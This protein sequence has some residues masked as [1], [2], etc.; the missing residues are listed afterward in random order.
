MALLAACLTLTVSWM[1][2]AV[3]PVERMERAGALS[4]QVQ[5]RGPDAVRV[6]LNGASLS[7]ATGLQAV[8]T[9]AEGVAKGGTQGSNP[10]AVHPSPATKS[11]TDATV[12]PA[13][14]GNSSSSSSNGIGSSSD[15][16][17]KGSEQGKAAHTKPD[18]LQLLADAELQPVVMATGGADPRVVKTASGSGVS[19]LKPLDEPEELAGVSPPLEAAPPGGLGAAAAGSGSAA[20]APRRGRLPPFAIAHRGASSELPEHTREAYER[21]IE[22]GADFIECDVVLTSDLVPLCRHEPNL[23]SSTDALAKFPD[24][25]RTYVIDGEQV[26]GVFSVDL[27]AAEVAT[28]HA[29]QPWPF[30]DQSHN[31]RYAVAT[32]ADYLQVARSA[33]RSV[34]IYPETKHPSWTN[35]LPAVRAANTTLEDILLAALAAAGFDSALGSPGW[36]QRPVFL[37]SFEAASL[38]YMASRSCAP[39]ILLLGDWEDWVA[40]DSNRTLADLTDDR[41]LAEIAGWAAGLGMSKSSLVRW[42]PEAAAARADANA[43]AGAA[44]ANAA[45]AASTAAAVHSSGQD[46]A[47]HAAGSAGA[48]AAGTASAAASNATKAVVKHRRRLHAASGKAVA[49]A[50]VATAGSGSSSSSSTGSGS[51]ARAAPGP[52]PGAG[53]YVTT[54]VAER[55]QSHGLQVH[56]YTLRPEPQFFLPHLTQ[57]VRSRDISPSAPGANATVADEYELFLEEVMA[58]D[59]MFADHMPSLQEWLRQHQLGRSPLLTQLAQQQVAE[60]GGAGRGGGGGG[61]AGKGARGQKG[62]RSG[63]GGPQGQGQGRGRAGGKGVETRPAQLGSGGG[64]DAMEVVVDAEAKEG[65]GG[66]GRREARADRGVG[67]GGRERA[68]YGGAGGGGGGGAG[69]KYQPRVLGNGL[70]C[71]PFRGVGNRPFPG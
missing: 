4:A 44:G 51:G 9:S 48:G 14:S 65:G 53:R 42:Q 69:G 38:R 41:S 64:A 71:E 47:A 3:D 33:N 32:L 28:L 21:A 59:G 22:E 29:V 13:R 70:R 39:G 2:A 66:G 30:R 17:H 19:T 60:A 54:G 23:A 57:H 20:R 18:M 16:K 61:G 5:E 31:G 37:Q 45:G 56:I 62:R 58:V 12:Q 55:A 67:Q 11:L 36:R 24:R 35:A 63:S 8:S 43:G 6:S 25:R 46:T 34:G 68:A 1:R 7:G 26:T 49:A 50:L 10:A 52:A 27:T 15:V 40:P